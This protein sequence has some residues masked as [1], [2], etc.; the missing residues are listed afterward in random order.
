MSEKWTLEEYKQ[1]CQDKISGLIPMEDYESCQ[2]I[3]DRLKAIETRNIKRY[4]QLAFHLPSLKKVGFLNKEMSYEQMADRIKDCLG[5]DDIFDYSL[6][7]GV[8]GI[9]CYTDGK[10]D[11]INENDI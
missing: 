9:I 3:L 11:W 7:K 8:N 2:Y 4:L 1:L 6:K 5:L 10:A